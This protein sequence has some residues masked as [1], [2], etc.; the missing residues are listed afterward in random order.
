M[1]LIG[2]TGTQTG[3]TRAQKATFSHLF[4][5]RLAKEICFAHGDC[6]GADSDAHDI[7][8]GIMKG[9]SYIVIHP[10]ID[11]SKRAFKQGAKHVFPPKEYLER[12]HN[13]VAT[14]DL[15][16]AAPKGFKEEL[17]S[18]TWA[19]IRYAKKQ[20]KQICIIYPDGE[21]GIQV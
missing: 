3:M 5:D 13:I 15:L 4:R 10:P 16:I 11:D 7:V 17:R 1:K 19:T 18:G 14:C 12:N 2:F 9:K 20:K 21:V 6:I 8:I